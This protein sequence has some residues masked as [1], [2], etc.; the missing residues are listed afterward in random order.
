MLARA[1]RDVIGPAAS[2]SAAN[3]STVTSAALLAALREYEVE[4][5]SRVLKISVRSNL[6]GTVLQI[7]YA[8]VSPSPPHFP[9]LLVPLV[10]CGKQSLHILMMCCHSLYVTCAADADADETSTA[11]RSWQHAT[12]LWRSFYR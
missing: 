5:S 1:L 7:P 4:R 2:T 8:P 9:R 11:P 12:T 3:V 10:S 6:M